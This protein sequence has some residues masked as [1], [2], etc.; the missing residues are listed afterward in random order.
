MP[1]SPLSAWAPGRVNLIGEHTDYSGGL[2]L[3][4]AIELGIMVDVCAVTAQISLT[5]QLLGD[6]GAFAADGSGPSSLAQAERQCADLLPAAA[7]SPLRDPVRRQRPHLRPLHCTPTSS[8]D[9]L[10]ERP[11]FETAADAI[12]GAASGARSL[13][14]AVRY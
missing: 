14:I 10:I 12:S 9:T 6:A 4:V 8:L 7:R 11:S 3:P 1:E 5:S 13:A 2:V